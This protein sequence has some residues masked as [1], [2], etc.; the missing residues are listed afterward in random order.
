VLAALTIFLVG[1]LGVLSLL[2]SG[3]RLHQESRRTGQALLVHEELRLLVE[4]E[5]AGTPRAA[6]AKLAEPVAPRPVPGR[7][8]Y[9]Y[10]YRVQE[11][12]GSPPY[13][14]EITL[15]WKEG[16]QERRRVLREVLPSL[17]PLA[18]RVR[19]LGTEASSV[20]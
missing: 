4:G 11:L 16:G 3:T 7:E 2:S 18:R 17:Q 1:I 12:P 19:A 14:L 6:L 10:S 9:Q 13:L 20:P 8:G 15:S 5:L